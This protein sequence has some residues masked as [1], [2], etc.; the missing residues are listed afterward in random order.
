MILLS[1][2]EWGELGWSARAKVVASLRSRGRL[3]GRERGGEE[4]R[5]GGRSRLE[6]RKRERGGGGRVQLNTH[7]V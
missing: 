1:F 4:G 2:V 3:Y 7:I 5:E 6:G